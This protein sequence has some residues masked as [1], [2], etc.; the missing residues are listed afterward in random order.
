[1]KS[2]RPGQLAC[3]R[4]G[5]SELLAWACGLLPCRPFRWPVDWERGSYR[6]EALP[7]RGSVT[8]GAEVV[9][10]VLAIDGDGGRAEAAQAWP[11]R[12][13]PID[14]LEKGLSP[15]RITPSNVNA[16]PGVRLDFWA[17][18]ERD[19]M[20]DGSGWASTKFRTAMPKHS[21]TGTP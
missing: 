3:G 12:S 21:M 11:L 13:Q 4:C 1:M 16:P 6:I 19:D 14:G 2:P 7:V 10:T 18:S 9:A 17:R 15:A 8:V 20:R 5:P